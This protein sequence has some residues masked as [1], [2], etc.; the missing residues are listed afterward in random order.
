M[1][2]KRFT[3]IDKEFISYYGGNGYLISNGE[4][5]IWLWHSKEESQKV[6]D[7]LNS[8]IDENEQLK[9]YKETYGDEIVHIKH[10][11][12][13]MMENERTEL[14]RSVLKQLWEAIQ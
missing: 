7:K 1:T 9:H 3:I 11:I 6:C 2:E 13:D 8:I 5:K 14:G 12:K 10:T 4:C